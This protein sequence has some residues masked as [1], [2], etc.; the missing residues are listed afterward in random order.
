MSVHAVEVRSYETLSVSREEILRYMGGRAT[1]AETEVLLS[2]AI[3]EA[4]PYLAPRVCLSRVPI[5]IEEGSV[6]LGFAQT[7]SLALAGALR[8]CREAYVFAA[9][10]GLGIDRL[11]LRYGRLSP[12]RALCIDAIGSAAI[13]ATCDRLCAELS[14]ALLEEGS[15]LGMRFSPGYGDLALEFQRELFAFLNCARRIGLTLGEG[16]LMSPAKSVTAIAGIRPNSK[17]E[18]G[19]F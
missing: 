17:E 19:I 11:L 18:K 13:E 4:M 9:T 10:V 5:A 3:A 16:L 14:E 7:E 8:G 1:G 12:A 6:E 15:A 2:E